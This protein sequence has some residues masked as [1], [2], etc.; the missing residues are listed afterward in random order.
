[1][2]VTVSRIQSSIGLV[3]GIEIEDT[4]NKLMQLAAQ[5]RETLASR[6]KTL[7][8]EQAAINDLTGLTLGVQLAIRRF[9]TSS[10]FDQK[11]VAS[12]N[13]ALLTATA[14]ASVP[15]GQY[16]FVAVRQ[17]TTHQLISNGLATRDEPLGA[18][19]FSF[20]F[21]GHVD[22]AVSLDDLNGGAGVA[23]GKIKIT[24]RDGATA[25]IDLSSAQT[26]D[27]VLRAI[28]ASEE[29]EVQATA[30]GD[31]LKLTDTSGGL[32]NLRVQEVSG[33]STAADL[34]LA[35]INVAADE[36]TGTDL[37]RLF[38]GL[39]LSRL[40]DGSGLGL[41]PELAEL[42]IT[43][44][45]NSPALAIDLDPIGQPTPQTLG[46][47]LD[48]INAADP[49]R[50]QASIS[51][52]GKRIVL[53]DLTASSGGTFAVSSPFA[54]TAAEE[55]G[56]TT[57]AAGGTL[58][59][60]RIVS[61]LKTTLLSSLG[62]G[63]GLG[64]LGAVAITNR[65]GVTTNV[66][67]AGL[68][69]LDD[70]IAAINAAGAGV[71][72]EINTAGNGL[73]LVD[74]TGGTSSNLIVADGD[75]TN[76]ATKLELMADIAAG[77]IDG[78]SLARQ[79][80]NRGTLLSSY[81][82][83]SGVSETS[84]RITASDG[85]TG[86]VN[87]GTIGAETIGDV[88][89][90]INDLSMGVEAR[91]NDAGDGI[92]LA[93]TAG[94]TGVLTVVENGSGSAAADLHILGAA[95]DGVIDGSTRITVEIDADDTLDDLV[96]KINSLG[97]GV[98]ANV[99][100]LGNGSLKYRLSLM[101]DVPGKAGELVVDGSAAGLAFQELSPA[102]DALL[103][104]GTGLASAIYSSSTNKFEDVI[105]GL[106]VTINGADPSPVVVTVDQTGTAAADAIQTFVDN[107]N[108]L[109]DKLATYTQYN[110]EANVKGTLF[111]SS[112]TLRID[113]DLSQMLTARYFG[114]G[115]VQS[116][117]ELGLSL[118]DTGKLSFDRTKFQARYDADPEAVVEFFTDETFGFTAK[119][120]AILERIV[121]RDNSAL[122]TRGQTLARQIESFAERI[123]V[124]D[125]RLER[126]RERLLNDFF[127][128]ELTVSKI[129]NSLNAI[130][131]I[132]AIAPLTGSS[133][134]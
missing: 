126:K 87:L 43:F 6:L 19:S 77:S 132:Q 34:G 67:L 114:V 58:I 121:G 131:Q 76:T 3:T 99:L 113:A 46:D 69:T 72:A 1:L 5:P 78:G 117:G 55:L 125:G 70:I 106:D 103:Q 129:R 15:N 92:E 23:R 90:A 20:G 51:A 95:E 16:Q 54:G 104:Y 109:R 29:I 49:A 44:R 40:N 89:D 71:T 112:E 24:D 2:A 64:T 50:L 88:I 11:S 101:S 35:A 134:N 65:N 61:G 17:A 91:I 97:A 57:T 30:S 59:G 31:R 37:V 53:T 62:G 100:S 93:D 41:R 96:T 84:F 111:G 10:L 8:A 32:G 128:L 127:R 38:D 119:A 82:G 28:N 86:S 120:D 98:T 18:G 48:R 130:S 60:G 25:V 39:T 33:G 80:V 133:S 79:V 73:R 56:L 85:S 94:G 105:E 115:D 12:S 36:A 42:E 27:D 68:E 22:Q 81:N 118:D 83:G 21:G 26:I 14:A 13:A 124:W 47:V 110:A 74:S 122:V 52:D 63:A 75:A 107:Y 102:Q 45:D 66:N 116:L 9:K 108:K 123:D 7:Q 4:V